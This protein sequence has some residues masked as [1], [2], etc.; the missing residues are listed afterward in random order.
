M[1]DKSASVFD[2]LLELFCDGLV[3]LLKCIYVYN[4]QSVVDGVLIRNIPYRTDIRFIEC[5]C[6]TSCML[7]T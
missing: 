3:S 1:N 6:F 7:H 5:I 4:A 2:A